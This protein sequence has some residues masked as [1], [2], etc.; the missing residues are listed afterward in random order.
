MTA[1]TIS[2]ASAVRDAE[3][4]RCRSITDGDFETLE[5][6]LSDNL[7]YTH[8]SGKAEN[9][10]E[11]IAGR[12]RSVHSIVRDVTDVRVFGDVALVTGQCTLTYAEG[13]MGGK[14]IRTLAFQAWMNEA[15]TWRLIGHLGAIKP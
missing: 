6:L 7:I 9:K 5:D 1:Q 11:F 13:P 4:R 3:E 12:K 8:A 10:A 15:G 2:Q 14:P